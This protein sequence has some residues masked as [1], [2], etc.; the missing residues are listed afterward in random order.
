MLWA[1]IVQLELPFDFY[2]NLKFL[3]Q[4]NNNNNLLMMIMMKE[5]ISYFKFPFGVKLMVQITRH[6]R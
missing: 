5:H 6:T 4:N 2:E 3:L 1:D